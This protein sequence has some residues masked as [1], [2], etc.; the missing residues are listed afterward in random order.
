MRYRAFRFVAE[1]SMRPVAL[2]RK[3]WLHVDSEKSGPK[4][5]AILSVVESCRR[6]GVPV[7]R[8]PAGRVAGHSAHPG[9]M[10]LRPRLTWIGRTDT[11]QGRKPAGEWLNKEGMG[12]HLSAKVTRKRTMSKSDNEPM[13][14]IGC[15]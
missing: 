8:L 6:L 2:G 11:L 14:A 10:E 7:K 5:A 3:N 4:V 1:N 9:P 12:G 13:V 15:T